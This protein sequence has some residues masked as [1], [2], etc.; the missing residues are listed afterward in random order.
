MRIY[1]D[2]AMQIPILVELYFDWKLI[3]EGRKDIP[4]WGR[5]LII[6]AFAIIL[7]DGCR[8]REDIQDLYKNIIAGVLPYSF[9]DPALNI[10]RG[11]PIGYVGKT[12]MYDKFLREFNWRFV[13]F[14]RLTFC[15]LL[16]VL[17]HAI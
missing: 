9:F 3:T 4:W 11:K 16:I 8:D 10:L 5:C 17:Y 14:A 15:L 13:L 2:I 1:L 7:C 6:G 12:K